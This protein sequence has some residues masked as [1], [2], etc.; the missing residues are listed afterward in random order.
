M[1]CPWKISDF[2]GSGIERPALDHIGFKVESLEA[3][4]ADLDELVKKNPSLMPAPLGLGPEGEVRK[5]LLSQ[6]KLGKFQLS[7]L[8]GVLIDVAEN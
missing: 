2:K 8:D 6:C 7:D 5:N 3:F 1:V 4:K